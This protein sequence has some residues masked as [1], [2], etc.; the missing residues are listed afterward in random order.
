M[1]EIEISSYDML[2]MMIENVYV[3][4]IDEPSFGNIYADI[5][6]KLSETASS[7]VHITE[8]DEEPPTES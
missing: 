8:S 6:V 7:F 1:I 4:A 5:C 3:K 2:T